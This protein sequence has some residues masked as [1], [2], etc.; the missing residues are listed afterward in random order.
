MNDDILSKLKAFTFDVEHG[1]PMDDAET[2]MEE[3]GLEI[4]LLRMRIVRLIEK[5]NE[6]LIN[7]EET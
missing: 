2:L 6:F 5:H 1:D 7:K 4:I 3:A